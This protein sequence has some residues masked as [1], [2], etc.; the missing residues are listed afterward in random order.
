MKLKK[1]ASVIG[2]ALGLSVIAAPAYS[3]N[4]YFFE[5]DDLEWMLRADANGVYQE[6]TSGNLGVGDVLYSVFE[7]PIFEI[8]GVNALPAGMELTGVSA[9]EVESVVNNNF[10]FK[11]W[12][13]FTSIY[14]AG[15]MVAMFLNDLTT[16]VDLTGATP[17][18]LSCSTRALCTTQATEGSLFQ[19]D[20][21]LG[22][23]DE[24]WNAAATTD[25]IATIKAASQT[26]IFA[27]YNAG[28]SNIFNAWGP[29]G[30]INP[31]NDTECA[32]TTGCVQALF[33]GTVSG[34]AG[35]ENTNIVATSDLQERKF[36]PEPASLALLGIGLAGIGAVR[37]R[38]RKSQ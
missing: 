1:L 3:G 38:Q 16:D 2:L 15:A 5:D 17:A 21:F 34:A 14:G 4:L 27:F 9:I 6:T 19:V 32:D 31:L 37:R 36:V 8:N 20:G 26:T 22:D 35:F 23:P 25:N 11:P 18:E 10:V 13:G 24:F 12:A 28:L 33:S 7:M 29:V 30:F